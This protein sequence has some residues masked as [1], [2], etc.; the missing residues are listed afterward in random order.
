MWDGGVAHFYLCTATNNETG[1]M[2]TDSSCK[3][4]VKL[5]INYDDW[6]HLQK[7]M[8]TG[9]NTVCY[10]WTDLMETQDICLE[11]HENSTFK[12]TCSSGPGLP[13]PLVV[14][15]RSEG[16][17]TW[18][19]GLDCTWSLAQSSEFPLSNWPCEQ[20]HRGLS[21]SPMHQENT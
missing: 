7:V 3:R 6:S 1:D 2:W 13:G 15:W 11:L 9:Q 20:G 14:G 17:H 8:A 16:R 10:K 4:L 5:T 18:L 19:L 21:S 12:S